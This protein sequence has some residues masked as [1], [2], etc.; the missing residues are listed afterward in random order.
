VNKVS[1]QRLREKGVFEMENNTIYRFLS[2]GC[3]YEQAL[4]SSDKFPLGDLG[5]VEMSIRINHFA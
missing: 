4:Y 2:I 3:F 5:V 1:I